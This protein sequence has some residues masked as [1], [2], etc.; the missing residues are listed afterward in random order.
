MAQWSYERIDKIDIPN[1][2]LLS[3]FLKLVIK[4]NR[5]IDLE[6]ILCLK[7]LIKKYGEEL[8]D[9]WNEIFVIITQIIYNNK[10]TPNE[11][12]T[13]TISDIL[14]NIKLLIINNRFYGCIKDY[15]NILEESKYLT[16]DSL[17]VL[18]TKFKLYK[19]Y[20][21]LENIESIFIEMLIK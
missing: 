2:V 3:V 12:L 11:N 21:F 8:M 9:E 18:K 14:D 1:A 16:N 7:R 17:C 10:Q 20:D 4:V 6:I 5:K 15:S 19:Y 13:K